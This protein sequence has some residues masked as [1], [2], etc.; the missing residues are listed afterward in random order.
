MVDLIQ[1]SGLVEEPRLDSFLQQAKE[2]QTDLA[3]L[4]VR[5]VKE[6]LLTSFQA[7]QLLQGRW[8]GFYLGKYKVLEPLGVGGMARVFLCEHTVMRR[9]VA[10]KIL[11]N[12]GAT[13]SSVQRF[14][15]E[16]RAAGAMEHPN[17][18]RAYDIDREGQWIFLVMEYIDGLTL[19]ELVRRDGALEVKRA[20]EYVR[21][22]ALG[23]QH[24]HGLG[25]VHRDVKPDN[26]LLTR[27]GVVK[28]LDL[29]LARLFGDHQDQLTKQIDEKAILGSAD[30]LSPE[31]V[32][33]SSGVDGRADVYSLGATFYYLITGM[34]PFPN[35]SVAEKL[36]WRLVGD[37]RPVRSVRPEVPESLAAVIEK[38]LAKDVKKRYQTPQE[39]ADALAGWLGGRPAAATAVAAGRP[40]AAKR[41]DAVKVQ[42]AGPAE[43]KRPPDKP[44]KPARLGRRNQAV[45]AGA[46]A[47]FVLVSAGAVWVG[48]RYILPVV[49]VTDPARAGA[50]DDVPQGPMSVSVARNRVGKSVVVEMEVR[51]TRVSRN[52]LAY[53]LNSH[54]DYQD[55]ANFT[56]VVHKPV[57]EELVKGDA[58]DPQARLQGKVVRVRGKVQLYKGNPQ[59]ELGAADQ[60][61]VVSR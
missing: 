38:M 41:P 31:Q 14:Y 5:L 44:G 28:V 3:G 2:E 48:V 53:F 40:A 36:M 24:A 10:V 35:G 12:L 60:L 22:A 8:R 17:V 37:P 56:V 54:K 58:K 59:I 27:E 20:A 32:S 6:G 43:K 34:P 15:R 51:S 33:H 7:G 42:P 23:L 29:G 26:L 25:W 55:R 45:L 49:G 19:G 47:L 9:R 61:E 57:M 4:V 46:A 52:G 39:V 30:Y 11:P 1:K 50:P 21:Q 16:A 18:V 13:E